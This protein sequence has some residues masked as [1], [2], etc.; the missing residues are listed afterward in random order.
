[1]TQVAEELKLHP[2]L[3]LSDVTIEKES[4]T[5]TSSTN[6]RNVVVLGSRDHFCVNKDVRK[7]K[8]SSNNTTSTR[9][10]CE[11]LLEADACREFKRH[12]QLVSSAP[13]VWDIEDLVKMGRKKESCPYF[14]SRTMLSDAA[15]VLCPYNYI[16][17]SLIRSKMDVKIENSVVIFDEAH[18]I[19]DVARSIASFDV[20][21]DE[22]ISLETE[23]TKYMLSCKDDEL[24]AHCKKILNMTKGFLR[25]GKLVSKQIKPEDFEKE[26]NVWS[27]E[28]AMGILSTYCDMT[29]EN[30]KSFRDAA[31][32]LTSDS[33]EARETRWRAK[34]TDVLPGHVLATMQG[35]VHVCE[36]LYA[37]NII[38]DDDRVRDNASHYRLVLMRSTES[39]TNRGRRG[40]RGRVEISYVEQSYLL[41]FSKLTLTPSHT[42]T[43]THTTQ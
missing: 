40:R 25:W 17:D 30:F 23:L 35:F 15:I 11:E 41:Y 33:V 34:R 5:T 12:P 29:S 16:L 22:L 3:L 8:S 32:K 42:H 19:C 18:N 1:M 31:S 37:R 6:R 4:E 24:K 2:D 14:A 43:Q 28:E 13:N 9:E 26:Q 39:S 36:L 21:F 7:Q 38:S 20:S 10:L 27:G